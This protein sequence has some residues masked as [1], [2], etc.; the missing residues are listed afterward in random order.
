[1]TY[2]VINDVGVKTPKGVKT[3]KRGQVIK[4]AAVSAKALIEAGKIE[5]VFEPVDDLNERMAIMGENCAPEEV[6]PYISAFN[7][8][9]IPWNSDPRYHYW[10]KSGKSILQTLKELEADGEILKRYRSLYSDN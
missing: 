9:V 1:M 7:T 2:K 8:L 3:L 6:K 4:L 10:K 5:P